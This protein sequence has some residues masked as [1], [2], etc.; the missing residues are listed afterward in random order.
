M[1]RIRR[2]LLAYFAVLLFCSSLL[3]QSPEAL[4]QKPTQTAPQAT[5]ERSQQ[6][7]DAY[8][9]AM[10]EADQ[11]ISAEVRAHSELMKNLEYLTTQI[12]P[13]L[14]GSPQMQAASQW[15]LK[16]FQDYHVEAHL[17]T[18]EIAH[19]WTRGT[20]TAEITSPIQ[21]RIGIHALGWSKA[22]DGEITGNVMALN[23]TKPAD[24]EPYKGKLKGAIVMLRKPY[25][26]A[27]EDPNPENA[28]DAVIAPARGIPQPNQMAWRDRLRLLQQVAA[29]G[30]ALVLS[31]SG[32]PH[33]LFNM[34]GGFTRYSASDVPMAFLTHEDYGLIYR[35]LQAGA[36][37]MKV[38]LQET[39][40]DKPAPA[41]ITVAEIKGSEH[42]E[43]RVIVGGHL[44]SWDLGQGAL[45]NGTGAMATLEAARA[46]QALGWKPKRTITFILFTGEEQGGLGADTFLKNHA[47]EIAAIDAVLIHDTGTG[48]VFSISLDNLWETAALMHEI[49]QPLQEV[50]DLQP[51]STR[52]F[53]SSDHVP[54]LN[55]GVP[56]Y[57]CVQLPAQYREAHHSQTDTFDKVLPDQINEG[58]ALLAAWAW[59]VSEIPQALPHH[60]E[61]AS[62]MD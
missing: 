51:L 2:H 56:A 38:N 40:S 9:K 59:N 4:P 27:Q 20:E 58:A 21:R 36:V 10:E 52:Y 5:V 31:D 49:Y 39:F 15:T 60:A 54:F 26:L 53:G 8:R 61:P 35:L 62:P 16:R 45:D 37:T 24:L 57:F 33:S 11:K 50:F 43:E 46:L 22:T 1:T 12:G 23:I 25:D 44:D 29:Q 48:K 18:A 30:P 3:A 17:E 47:S 41:S 19:G 13:R 32:L 28:Y 42:P 7:R 6:Q 14:T 55:K 34:T